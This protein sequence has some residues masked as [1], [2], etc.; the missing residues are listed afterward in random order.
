[1]DHI[2]QGSSDIE[3]YHYFATPVYI[4]KKPEFLETVSL[5]ANEK[6]QEALIHNDN[7]IDEVFPFIMSTSM[8][9]DPRI[10]DFATYIAES[11][12][13]ILAEQ[14][15]AMDGFHTF[16]TEMWCQQHEY[17]SSMDYHAHGGSHIVGFYFLET[18]ENC[19]RAIIH[20]PRP[21]RLMLPLPEL[22]TNQ[23]TL[24]SGMINF[25]PEPGMV[26]FA[27]AYLPHSFGRN[28]S[29]QPFKFVHFNIGVQ[30]APNMQCPATAEV[31]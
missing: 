27:P 10:A 24:A 14:G 21:S 12:W 4:A 23:A 6:L 17:S 30:Q 7:K 28:A 16:F 2:A 19:P 18:P 22:D 15:Y 29:K 13:A 1:M 11:S 26:I 8:L 25:K 20:D 9:D 3:R 31:I 5:I